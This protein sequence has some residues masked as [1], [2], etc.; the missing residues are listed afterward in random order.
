MI[1]SSKTSTQPTI[2]PNCLSTE[3]DRA[4]TL[5]LVRFTKKVMSH[6]ILRTFVDHELPATASLESDD[7]ILDYVLRKGNSA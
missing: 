3:Y 6:E 4:I 2:T 7:E 1:Q 5:S